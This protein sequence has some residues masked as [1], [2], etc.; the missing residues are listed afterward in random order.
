VADFNQAIAVVLQH[1]GGFVDDLS[2]AGGMTNF[3]ICQRDNPNLDIK[4]LTKQDA[5]NYY[6]INWWLKYQ[7]FQIDDDDLATYW[8]DHA[9]NVG[10]KPITKII[11]NTVN[12]TED[13][14]IGINT[15]QAV[16]N[17]YKSE[18]LTQIQDKLWDYYEQIIA[19]HPN[20][21]KYK[22]GWHSRCY[23]E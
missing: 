19:V 12:T 14:I 3:G 11:Q 7:F 4:N 2:D 5:I 22:N 21:V 9:V 6:K 1:E 18:M 23:G 16:N 17:N 13:G 20:D 8:F 10:I 15:I